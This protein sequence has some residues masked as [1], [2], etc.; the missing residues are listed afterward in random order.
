MTSSYLVF[1]DVRHRNEL[2]G[3]SRLKGIIRGPRSASAAADKSDLDRVATGRVH[4]RYR[5]ASQ[6]GHRGDASCGL[7]EIPARGKRIETGIH[8][9]QYFPSCF[10]V[11]D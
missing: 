2:Y 5:Y 4:M 1:K 11:N 8:A 9:P 3:S 10:R 7:D 6:S